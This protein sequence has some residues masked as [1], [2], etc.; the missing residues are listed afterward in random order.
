M[1]INNGSVCSIYAVGNDKHL[2]NTPNVPLLSY[3][4]NT[5]RNVYF[6]ATAKLM[7]SRSV[8]SLYQVINYLH[9]YLYRVPEGYFLQK[10]ERQHADR[11]VQYWPYFQQMTNKREV[12]TT[13]IKK[14]TSIGIF[15]K[16]NPSQPVSWSC[17]LHC[18]EIAFAYTMPEH[19]R[20]GLSKVV[21]TALT[22]EVLKS[23]MTPYMAAKIENEVI[24]KLYKKI[25]FV[26]DNLDNDVL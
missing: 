10:L 9:M 18:G 25:G 20:K 19:R 23:N 4:P 13:L 1:K 6:P 3:S 26:E 22:R 8:L 12:I 7:A 15:M 14:F 2:Y 5:Y 21:I 11:V 24:Q 17:L 16:E